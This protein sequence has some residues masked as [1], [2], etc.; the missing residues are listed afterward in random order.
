[1][2]LLKNRQKINEIDDEILKLFEQR[3]QASYDIAEYKIKNNMPIVQSGRE[4]EI[5]KKVRQSVPEDLGNAAE[6]LFTTLMDISKCKQYQKFYADGSPITFDSL[7]LT[8]NSVVAVPGTVGSYS[9]IASKQF[10][11]NGKTVFY[12]S[13]HEVFDA[14]VRGEADFGVLPFANS[15]TGSVV[16]TY[17]LMRNHD[18]KICAQTKVKVDHCLAVKKGVKLEDIKSIYSHEQGIMQCSEFI[19][20]H[21]FKTHTYSN[22]ALAA[23]FIKSSD[24]PLGAICSAYCADDMGLEILERG[25]ANA[26]ENYTKFMLISKKTL[27]PDNANIISVSLSLPHT[28][29]S[30]YRLLTKFSV[31]GLNLCMIE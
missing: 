21:G 25:I 27:C 9:H 31:A 7:D 5:L 2:E 26:Q 13:F 28:A 23:S 4:K 1:M 6:A 17:E 16:Q 18:F 11:K 30:L 15:T 10:V 12:E 8:G 20:K 19:K 29:S 14:V 22:T 3:M 24:K